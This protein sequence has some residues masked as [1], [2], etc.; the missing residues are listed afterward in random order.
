M[1]N[2]DKRN[3]VDDAA[4]RSNV[5]DFDVAGIFECA[6]I[7]HD[8]DISMSFTMPNGGSRWW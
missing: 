1:P 7:L 5:I 4:L 6:D 3:S 8:V 2:I